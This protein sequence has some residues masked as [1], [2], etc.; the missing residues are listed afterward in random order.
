MRSI[1][2]TKIK[3]KI[4]EKNKKYNRITVIFFNKNHNHNL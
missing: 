3:K 4:T 2:E 1:V